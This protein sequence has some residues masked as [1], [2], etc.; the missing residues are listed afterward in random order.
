V[1]LVAVKALPQ[2]AQ[3]TSKQDRLLE[4]VTKKEKLCIAGVRSSTI[5]SKP[6]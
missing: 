4:D 2:I 5:I 1:R 3:D 6:Y